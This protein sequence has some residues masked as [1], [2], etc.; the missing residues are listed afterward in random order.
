VNSA[1]KPRPRGSPRAAI[2]AALAVLLACAH[3]RREAP[4][5]PGAAEAPPPAER[6]HPSHELGLASYYARSLEGRLTASGARYDGRA[7]TC[8]HRTLPFGTRV[9]V[10][11]LETGR[12][13]VV[14]VTDRGPFAEGRIVDLSWAAASR[15]G[16]LARGIARVRVEPLGGDRD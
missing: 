2:V 7:L 15:L 6:A 14:R 10:T 11:D 9:R 5:G 16:I 3:G 1:A 12:S 4:E 8:A 13:V